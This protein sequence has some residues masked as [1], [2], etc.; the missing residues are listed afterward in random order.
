MIL[1]IAWS[2]M[3]DNTSTTSNDKAFTVYCRFRPLNKRERSL[4]ETS[5][6]ATIKIEDGGKSV[7]VAKH[8]FTFD[9]VVGEKV[10]QEQFYADFFHHE[11]CSF[12]NDRF[13]LSVITYGQTSSGKTWSIDGNFYDNTNVSEGKYWGILPRSLNTI[14]D[15]AKEE[16]SLE[17]SYYEIYRD[18]VVDLLLTS[19]DNVP[20]IRF[21][22]NI[23]MGG[24]E[25]LGLTWTKVKSFDD[26]KGL[27]LQARK[28]RHFASTDMNS[29][30][31]R[32]HTVLDIRYTRRGEK[33]PK[34]LRLIDLAGS[35]RVN[36]TNA[37]GMTLKE[38]ID[39]NRSLLYLR[40]LIESL[41]KA[42]KSGDCSAARASK[43]TRLL[44]YSIKQG[45]A[46]VILTLCCSPAADNV[47]ETLKTLDFGSLAKTVAIERPED[48]FTTPEKNG[49]GSE[50]S[51]RNKEMIAIYEAK[52]RDYEENL[53]R[54]RVKLADRD[55]E[56][57]EKRVQK[58][59]EAFAHCLETIRLQEEIITANM[60]D[61]ME[62]RNDLNFYE[63][64]RKH[65]ID[66]LDDEEDP[67]EAYE[68]EGGAEMMMERLDMAFK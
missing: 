11:I 58:Y 22:E 35:E 29:T 18:N 59:E 51:E 44:Y 39:I 63:K 34:H 57:L 65:L 23:Q 33:R 61:I 27:L 62:M 10:E 26:V 3:S 56:T 67:I 2:D 50:D 9:R 64:F 1:R 46:K 19:K 16:D 47:N 6:D 60:H 41:A 42:K 8:T 14:C 7:T 38:G 32:S 12:L 40:Q 21:F 68:D 36:K 43:L 49:G 20:K 66:S 5:E 28:A 13:D 24:L 15:L 54:L 53:E 52:I 45:R 48:L 17:L 31:S 55:V 37:T 25:M 30:S 4:G